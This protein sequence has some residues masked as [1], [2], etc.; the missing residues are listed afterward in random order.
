MFILGLLKQT[1]SYLCLLNC[2]G[3]YREWG[4]QNSFVQSIALR[5]LAFDSGKV[6]ND[7]LLQISPNVEYHF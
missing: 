4:H 7:Y 6:K 5:L 3:F 2:E 1:Y